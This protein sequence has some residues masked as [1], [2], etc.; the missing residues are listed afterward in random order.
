MPYFA[1][2]LITGAT[3]FQMIDEQETQKAVGML[4]T[5]LKSISSFKSIY[6]EYKSKATNECSDN[7]WRIQNNALFM[8]L[9]SFLER[10]HDILGKFLKK[11][12]F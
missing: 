12:C 11:I 6:F 7:P 4:K 9:D 8:R 10:C 1:F 3:I 2:D 5:V